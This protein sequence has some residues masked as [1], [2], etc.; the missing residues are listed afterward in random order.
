MGE[1]LLPG[2]DFA[3]DFGET[4]T[5]ILDELDQVFHALDDLGHCQVIEDFLALADDLAHLGFVET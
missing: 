5:E 2:V 3:R 4:G 1:F